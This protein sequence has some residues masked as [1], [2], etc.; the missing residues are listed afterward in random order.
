[1]QSPRVELQSDDGKNEN[2]EHNQESDLHKWSQSLED[3]LEYNLKTWDIKK[4]SKLLSVLDRQMDR[5]K[6]ICGH[7]KFPWRI[8]SSKEEKRT[9]VVL[10][11]SRPKSHPFF[12]V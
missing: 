4:K 9:A 6:E 5:R 3:G 10:P 11:K 8:W 2:G 1:M 12:T 7:S